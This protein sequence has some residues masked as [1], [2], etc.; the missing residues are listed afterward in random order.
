MAHM[1]VVHESLRGWGL[2]GLVD[3]VAQNSAISLKRLRETLGIQTVYLVRTTTISI[4]YSAANIWCPKTLTTAQLKRNSC[5]MTSWGGWS[6]K[7]NHSLRWPWLSDDDADIAVFAFSFVCFLIQSKCPC[8]RLA[9]KWPMA[10]LQT[11]HFRV[12]GQTVPWAKGPEPARIKL[13]ACFFLRKRTSGWKVLFGQSPNP[14]SVVFVRHVGRAEFYPPWPLQPSGR[15]TGAG[16]G[17]PPFSAVRLL[18][19]LLRCLKGW[20]VKANNVTTL[21]LGNLSDGRCWRQVW[22]TWPWP[23][24]TVQAVTWFTADV[25]WLVHL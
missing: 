20:R 4:S 21:D 3:C 22:L 8:N 7:G 24:A 14:K 25:E 6:T 16:E 23:V 17:Q 5:A 10:P 11:G 18:P 13:S 12:P 15:A 19:S 1:V 9:Q 2:R